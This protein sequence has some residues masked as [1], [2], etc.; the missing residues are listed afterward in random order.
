MDA[1]SKHGLIWDGP[2]MVTGGSQEGPKKVTRGSTPT[3]P[4]GVAK[5]SISLKEIDDFGPPRYCR[6][7]VR[8]LALLVQNVFVFE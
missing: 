5:S 1:E 7:W 4:L 8:A 6:R 3:N 2:K